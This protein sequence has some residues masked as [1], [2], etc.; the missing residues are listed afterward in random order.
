MENIY[1]AFR[2]NNIEYM[3]K[4]INKDNIDTLNHSDRTLLIHAI[5]TRND[6]KAELLIRMGADVNKTAFNGFSALTQ[7]SYYGR[8]KIVKLLL[9]QNCDIDYHRCGGTA[10]Q[11]TVFSRAH[12]ERIPLAKILIKAG[13]DP[14]LENKHEYTYITYIKK[15]F[16]GEDYDTMIR[17]IEKYDTL[18]KKTIRY[19]K[20]N[21]EMFSRNSIQNL[22]KDIRQNFDLP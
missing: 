17:F 12:K 6:S 8:V 5:E 18:Y 22:V 10:L 4:H 19:I 11:Y 21:R 15:N 9:E 20:K 3:R 1:E 7:A 2:T 14:Y 13:A 16:N